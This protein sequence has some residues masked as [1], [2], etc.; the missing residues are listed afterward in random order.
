[1]PYRGWHLG[2]V[3]DQDDKI[4]SVAV[5]ILGHAAKLVAQRAVMNEPLVLQRDAAGRHPVV[6]CPHSFQLHHALGEAAADAAPL[7]LAT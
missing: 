5:E 2:A 3:D 7:L 6:T 4:V 1:M